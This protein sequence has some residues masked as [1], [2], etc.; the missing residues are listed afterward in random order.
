MNR[1]LGGLAGVAFALIPGIAAAETLIVADASQIKW[2]VMDNKVYFRNFDEINSSWQGCCYTY[3]IDLA[4]DGGRAMFSVFLT[5]SAA[6]QRLN[7]FANRTANP[8]Q[9]TQIGDW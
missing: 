9:I 2:S 3:Y 4:T 6:R 5:R 1:I 8:S 7:F